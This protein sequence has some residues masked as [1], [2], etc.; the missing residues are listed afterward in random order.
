MCFQMLLLPLAAWAV[1]GCMVYAEPQAAADT[2]GYP[3]IRIERR[4]SE[5][6]VFCDG[7]LLL[8]LSK[9]NRYLRFRSTPRNEQWIGSERNPADLGWVYLDEGAKGFDVSDIQHENDPTQGQFTLVI[10][11]KKP[12]FESRIR[13]EITGIW[14]TETAKFKYLLQTRLDCALEDWY[15]HS[16]SWRRGSALGGSKVWTEV[17]DYCIEGIST[18]ERGMMANKA[19]RSKPVFYEWFVKSHDGQ[20]WKKWPKVH[21]PFP[22]RPGE[23]ITI[24]ELDDPSNAGSFYGF[25]DQNRGGWLT[26]IDKTPA[27]VIHEIC[28]YRFDVHHQLEGAIP[29]RGSQKDLSLEFAMTFEPVEPQRARKI[30]QAAREIPWRDAPEYDL[31]L[32]SWDN[33]FDTMLKDLPGEETWKHT[34]WWPSDYECFR[35]DTTGFDDS[36]SLSIRRKSNHPKKSSAFSTHSW[37]YPFGNPATRGKRVRLSAMIKTEACTGDVRLGCYSIAEGMSDVYYGGR[38]AAHPDGTPRTEGIDWHYSRP[39]T[40]T[41]DWTAISLEF[42]G[43]GHGQTLFLEQ[44]GAGQCWFDNVKIEEMGDVETAEKAK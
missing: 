44:T 22:V 41:N 26:R 42:E 24:H 18:A 10:T 43:T 3:D 30:I 28:W 9:G 12:Q 25:L 29:S 5:T 19:E 11:G 1:W 27:P 39:L 32:L 31:P 21:I 2:S 38:K 13:V 7:Q 14:L 20:T 33:R 15:S 36:Y 16:R 35:D 37:S 17:L 8:E 23:Y 40:G 34:V 4:T 6:L